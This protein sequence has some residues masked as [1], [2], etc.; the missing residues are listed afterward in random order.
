MQ[1]DTMAKLNDYTNDGSIDW[2]QKPTGPRFN[3]LSKEH[4]KLCQEIIGEGHIAIEVWVDYNV[5]EKFDDDYGEH[6]LESFS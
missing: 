1:V 5:C 2:A 4:Y 3:N 6:C